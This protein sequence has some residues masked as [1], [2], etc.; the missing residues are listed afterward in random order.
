M[1]SRTIAYNTSPIDQVGSNKSDSIL[2]VPTAENQAGSDFSALADSARGHGLKVGV[3]NNQHGSKAKTSF[4]ARIRQIIRLFPHFGTI[5]II[6]SDTKSFWSGVIPLILTA[7]FFSRRILLTFETAIPEDFFSKYSRFAFPFLKLVDSLHVQ[8]TWSAGVFL[9]HNLDVKVL[10]FPVDV[11]ALKFKQAGRFQPR[12]ICDR[13]LNDANNILCLLKAFVFVKQKYPRA[14][15]VLSGTGPRR[16]PLSKYIAEEQIHGIEFMDE[17]EMTIGSSVWDDAD[18]YVNPST[19]DRFPISISHA[20]ALGLPVVTTDAGAITEVVLDRVNGM[21]L[22]VNDCVGMAERIIELI[23]NENLVAALTAHARADI[24][25]Q[26]V[27]TLAR[28]WND[29]YR[30]H[31]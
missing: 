24:E 11:K 12:I 22:A 28:S 27:E 8:T 7:R 1:M 17:S 14:E 4:L 25:V 31:P 21:V 30:L 29:F 15:L 13:T 19:I 23:E 6:A 9:K 2:I 10:S 5:H 20:F 16:V 26:S 18:V 3:L